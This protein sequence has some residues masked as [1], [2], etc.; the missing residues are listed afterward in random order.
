MN[1]ALL[2]SFKITEFCK[3]TV[4]VIRIIYQK[5][6]KLIQ[7]DK[8]YT[9][10]G[11][12]DCVYSL[13]KGP[14]EQQFFSGAGD[15]MVVGW[16]IAQ[17]DEGKLVA[18][19]KNSVYALRYL[20]EQDILL[21]GHNF[22]GLHLIKVAEAKEIA[23]LKCTDANIFDIQVYQ[24]KAWVACGNGE[25]LLIDLPS[26]TVLERIQATEK[27]ARTIAISAKNQEV[28]VGFSDHQVRIFDLHTHELKHT[29]E[30]HSSSVFSVVY[31]PD[32][33]CLLTTGRDAQIK[34]WK[35]EDAYRM[36]KNIPAHMYA[37]NS[38]AFDPSGDY[39]ASA[40]MDKSIKL[41]RYSDFRLL[42]VLDKSRHAGH[43][44]SVNKLIWLTPSEELI[45]GS[46]DRNISIWNINFNEKS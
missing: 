24:D 9:F 2:V 20:P 44:T 19:L 29:L 43:A 32:E 16:D 22:E 8:K 21:V 46:D 36:V 7:V 6:N 25:L 18:R 15:G 42:K 11:H 45:S 38:L 3:L 27:A 12:K 14:G 17:P 13:E 40:S 30:G 41:W 10:S 31:S 37:I 26:V 23:S 4:E 34:V 28:A 5:E 35:S 33:S 1:Q 39:F